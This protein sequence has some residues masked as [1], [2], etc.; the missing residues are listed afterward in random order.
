M[1]N[2]GYVCI[3]APATDI[4][5]LSDLQRP[6]LHFNRILII[7]PLTLTEFVV[8]VMSLSKLQNFEAQCCVSLT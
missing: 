8:S 2:Q 1:H 7:T 4:S 3:S 5:P 6:L